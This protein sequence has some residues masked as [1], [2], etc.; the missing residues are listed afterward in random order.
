MEKVKV[1][2]LIPEPVHRAIKV[3]CETFDDDP[4]DYMARA[5]VGGIELN[6]NF[7]T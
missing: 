4:N 7:Q 5:I 2:L 6:F 3:I 1:E